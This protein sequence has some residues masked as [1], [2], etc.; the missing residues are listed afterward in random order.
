MLLPTLPFDY[1]KH[2]DRGERIRRSLAQ[3]KGGRVRR[4]SPRPRDG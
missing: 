4:A 3:P 1:V 2:L